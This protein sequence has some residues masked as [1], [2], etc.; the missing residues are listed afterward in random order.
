M[1]L[2]ADCILNFSLNR[3]NMLNKSTVVALKLRAFDS[4]YNMR[5]PV[6]RLF[7]RLHSLEIF[8]VE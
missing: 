3:L 4:G 6:L 8:I 1:H 5:R 2:L 7:P